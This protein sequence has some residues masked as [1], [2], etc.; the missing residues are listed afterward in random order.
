MSDCRDDILLFVKKLT[1]QCP[2]APPLAD[3]PME[4]LRGLPLA[5]KLEAVDMFSDGE[6]N[7][8]VEHHNQCSL[9]R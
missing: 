5:E 3:C 4:D 9:E 8:I 2:K 6:L 1:L 7:S